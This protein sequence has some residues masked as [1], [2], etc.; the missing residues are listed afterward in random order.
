MLNANPFAVVAGELARDREERLF[1]F[2]VE[3]MR[4][5]NSAD[6]LA[7][8]AAGADADEVGFVALLLSNLCEGQA[9]ESAA[10]ADGLAHKLLGAQLTV[11]AY[12]RWLKRGGVDV[13]R[14]AGYLD[15]MASLP[16]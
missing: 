15:H 14:L 16:V 11:D 10:A 9:T 12:E 7:A 1:D 4:A 8:V 6:W 3:Q 5:F 2:L 13:N